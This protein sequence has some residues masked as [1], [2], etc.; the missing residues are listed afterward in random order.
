MLSLS[1]SVSLRYVYW[2]DWGN[3][4]KIERSG[5]DGNDRTPLITAPDVHW[6]N[7]ITVDYTNKKL[8]WCDGYLN[9][10]KMSNMDGSGVELSNRNTLG[11]KVV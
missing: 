3:A 6:P 9:K 5:L 2:T 1:L 4:P 10:I 7:G 8:Y 11:G